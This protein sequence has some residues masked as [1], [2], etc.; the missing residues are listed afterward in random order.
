MTV[1]DLTED[2]SERSRMVFYQHDVMNFH[3]EQKKGEKREK[4]M[5]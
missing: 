4:L 2:Q 1:S 5:I 3:I